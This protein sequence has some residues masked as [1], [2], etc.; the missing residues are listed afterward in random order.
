MNI[1]TSTSSLGSVNELF[2][3]KFL[4]LHKTRGL[5]FWH[6]SISRKFHIGSAVDDWRLTLDLT[7]FSGPTPS[8]PKIYAELREKF[9]IAWMPYYN[10]PSDATID[11]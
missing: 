7:E 8:S 1:I 11:Q 10:D 3:I 5:E 6:D 4:E 2:L 9:L